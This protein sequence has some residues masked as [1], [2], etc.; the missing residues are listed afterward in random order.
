MIETKNNRENREKVRTEE[1]KKERKRWPF[2][3]ILPH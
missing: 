2:S 1:E 3:K